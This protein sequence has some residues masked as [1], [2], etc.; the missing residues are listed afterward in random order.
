MRA[1]EARAVRLGVYDGELAGAVDAVV[2]AFG[3]VGYA[4]GCRVGLR[5]GVVGCVDGWGK[6]EG[7]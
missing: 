7:E 6:C 2:C 3:G 1:P 4:F 5:D